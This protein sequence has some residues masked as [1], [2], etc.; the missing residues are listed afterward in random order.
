MHVVK[1]GAGLV[2]ILGDILAGETLFKCLL[3]FEWIMELGKGHRTGLDP[4]INDFGDTMH[5]AATGFTLQNNLVYKLLMQIHVRD[6]VA[7]EDIAKISS[8][9]FEFG[10]TADADGG[11]AGIVVTFPE[12]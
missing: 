11:F 6:L 9:V 12:R 2:D 5:G 7:G 4:T 10:H 3:I 8:F 1:P